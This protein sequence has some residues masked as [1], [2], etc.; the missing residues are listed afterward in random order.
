MGEGGKD[1]TKKV[2]GIV[3]MED[4]IEDIIQEE[5]EDEYGYHDEKNKRELMKKKLVMLFNEHKVENTLN[6]NEI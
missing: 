6:E 5:I 3:T 4:I 1:P 2:V